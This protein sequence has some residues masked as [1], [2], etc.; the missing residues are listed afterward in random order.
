LRF[1]HHV[2]PQ[3]KS[4]DRS[5]ITLHENN[6]STALIRNKFSGY[7]ALLYTDAKRKSYTKEWSDRSVYTH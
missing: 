3:N 1:Y 7:K 2:T 4:D 5:F 6:I